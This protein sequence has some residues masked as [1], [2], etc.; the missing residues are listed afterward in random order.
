LRSVQNPSV[1]QIRPGYCRSWMISA[2]RIPSI[3]PPVN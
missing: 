3:Y 2:I 1:S